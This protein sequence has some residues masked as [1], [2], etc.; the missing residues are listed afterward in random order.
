[1]AAQKLTK[2]YQKPWQLLVAV[3]LSRKNT[4]TRDLSNIEKCYGGLVEQ[5]EVESAVYNNYEMRKQELQNVASKVKA[6]KKLSE[7]DEERV[8]DASRLLASIEVFNYYQLLS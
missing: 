7:K 5:M 1:M 4:L 8:S 2:H 6:S 3:C